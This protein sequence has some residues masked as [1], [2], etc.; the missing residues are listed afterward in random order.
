M[1]QF[2]KNAFYRVFQRE[3]KRITS[4]WV[5]ILSTLVFPL[6]AF[7]LITAIFNTGVPRNL[8]VSVV[9]HDQSALSRKITRMID[10]TSIAEVKQHCT[11]KEEAYNLMRKG[12]N[13][14]FLY[15]PKNTEKDVYKSD[16]PEIV[17]YAD[18]TNLV[19]SGLLNKGIKTALSTL[20]IQIKVQTLLKKGFSQP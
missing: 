7:L 9:D 3:I 11:S 10:A 15:I 20:S 12:Q 6:I 2:E 14:A 19:T 17:L 1:K 16:A 5:T 13:R 4:E 18:N 8:S